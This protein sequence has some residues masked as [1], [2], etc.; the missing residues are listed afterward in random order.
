MKK[1]HV[2]LRPPCLFG[3]AW[4][5]AYALVD[6]MPGIDPME[7]RFELPERIRMFHEVENYLGGSPGDLFIGF[8]A[9]GQMDLLAQIGQIKAM[10]EILELKEWAIAAFP[11]AKNELTKEDWQILIHLRAGQL[12]SDNLM[13]YYLN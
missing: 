9:N 10:E 12:R 3:E 7:F 4:L 1:D 11:V 2:M 5:Q 8:F 13:D 6:L